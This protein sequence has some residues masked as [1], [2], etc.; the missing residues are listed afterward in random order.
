MAAEQLKSDAPGGIVERFVA[1]TRTLD[2]Q[3]TLISLVICGITAIF[4]VPI[5]PETDIMGA[6]GVLSIY[7]V[8]MLMITGIARMVL[9]R[10]R[11]R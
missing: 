4:M 1:Y 2:G 5:L 9:K 6:L 11:R 8:V 3:A 7:I 10:F